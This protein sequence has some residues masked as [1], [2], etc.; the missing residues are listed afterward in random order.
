[1]RLLHFIRSS[2][3]AIMN[4]GTNFYKF[5]AKR[6]LCHGHQALDAFLRF[7]HRLFLFQRTY[8]CAA[9]NLGHPLDGCR[10]NYYNRF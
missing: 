5:L 3:F 8:P 1:M 4:Q 2:I 10:S 7:Y 6:G 9:Q